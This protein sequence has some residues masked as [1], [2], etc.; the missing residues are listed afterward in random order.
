M[1]GFTVW[2]SFLVLK[3]PDI[4]KNNDLPAEEPRQNRDE[5]FPRPIHPPHGLCYDP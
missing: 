4:S 1:Q 5:E 3:I 2:T